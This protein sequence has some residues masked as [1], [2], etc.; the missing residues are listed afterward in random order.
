MGDTENG[1]KQTPFSDAWS[2]PDVGGTGVAG[3]GG[4]LDQGAGANGIVSSPWSNP[5]VPT[6]GGQPTADGL[7]SGRSARPGSIGGVGPDSGPQWD[8]TSYNNTVDKK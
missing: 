2:T 7:E 8:I 1:I 6:P 4:G 5:T 3:I